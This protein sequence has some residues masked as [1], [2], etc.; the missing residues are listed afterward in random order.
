MAACPA[1]AIDLENG[2]NIPSCVQHRVRI[3]TDC[4]DRCHA[5]YRCVYGREHRYP[6][7]ELAYHQ[8]LS[9]A[10]MRKHFEKE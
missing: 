2:W 6:E 10:A 8:R 1:N 4:V 9:F 5:R 7:D 3:A